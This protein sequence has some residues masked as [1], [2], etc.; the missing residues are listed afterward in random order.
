MDIIS[1]AN[2]VK[3]ARKLNT[4]IV[5]LVDTNADP[6]NITYPIPSND[7]AIK[8]IKLMLD[9]VTQA[10]ESGKSKAKASDKPDKTEK[11]DKSDKKD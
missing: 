4:P 8:T 1:D 11:T 3:E 10:I 6:T 9:Y 5:A 2:A 7:D